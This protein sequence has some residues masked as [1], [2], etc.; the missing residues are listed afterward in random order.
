MNS[1]T[2]HN[3]RPLKTKTILVQ[4]K[5]NTN[6]TNYC[7]ILYILL[8]GDVHYNPGPINYPCT[9]CN[10]K[11]LQCDF[12]D[13]WTH[14][15]CTSLSLNEYNTLSISDDCY[16]CHLC[17]DRLPKITESFFQVSC[18]RDCNTEFDE[19]SVDKLNRPESDKT[20]NN[21]SDVNNEEGGNQFLR[22]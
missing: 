14:L 22:V 10:K 17:E 1:I 16:F 15:K 11:A 21:T 3:G 13:D 20:I 12:C 19:T 9:Y 8:S 2:T 7:F 5:K 6:S 18:M 4:R